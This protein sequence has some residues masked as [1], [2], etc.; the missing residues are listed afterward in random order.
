MSTETATHPVGGQPRQFTNIVGD[1]IEFDDIVYCWRIPAENPEDP[2]SFKVSFY[3]KGSS[4]EKTEWVDRATYEELYPF[5][6]E[7]IEKLNREADA[8]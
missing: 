2:D 4:E 3:P 6:I 1:R 5:K 7:Y 8:T